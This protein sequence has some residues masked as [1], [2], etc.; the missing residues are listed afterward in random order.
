MK[1]L[2]FIGAGFVLS[3]SVNATAAIQNRSFNC[4]SDQ[5]TTTTKSKLII[6]V[7]AYLVEIL[8]IN[9]TSVRFSAT[10][11]VVINKQIKGITLSRE[12][13]RVEEMNGYLTIQGKI[14]AL[15]VAPAKERASLYSSNPDLNE[16]PMFCLSTATN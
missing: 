2:F 9:D 8:Y 3:L 4:Q 11:N 15:A 6:T 13:A 7:P 16:V 5:K 1:K 12:I 14:W 10:K